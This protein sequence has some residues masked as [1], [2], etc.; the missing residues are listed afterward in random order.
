MLDPFNTNSTTPASNLFFAMRTR[1][2][3][4]FVKWV[5][6]F[7]IKDFLR[8]KVG[9]NLLFITETEIAWITITLTYTPY[10]YR[11]SSNGT[12]LQV[13]WF[14]ANNLSFSTLTFDW[15]YISESDFLAFFTFSETKENLT[16]SQTSGTDTSLTRI[17]TD[18]SIK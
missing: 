10:L 1:I 7:K 3:S 8:D 14:G 13:I 18:L 12:I 5:K 16:V 4:G 15:L 2:D 17:S 6:A 11:M 9:V